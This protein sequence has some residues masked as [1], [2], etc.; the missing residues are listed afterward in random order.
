M[1]DH[2]HVLSL[3]DQS[4]K[5]DDQ[6]NFYF[7]YHHGSREEFVSISKEEAREIALCKFSQGELHPAE[8]NKCVKLE[9]LTVQDF[10]Q[11]LAEHFQEVGS[12]R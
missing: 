8:G 12:V 11:R 3:P 1:S 7:Y 6:G 2:I 5:I 9:L 4:V 10:A